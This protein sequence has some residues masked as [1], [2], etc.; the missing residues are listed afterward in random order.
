MKSIR[1][2]IMQIKGNR[3][4][5]CGIQ[6]NSRDPRHPTYATLEHIIP[7]AKGGMT[8]DD[9]LVIACLGCN[10]KKGNKT[11]AEFRA[12]PDEGKL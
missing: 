11:E 1:K 8:I 12:Q 2:Q 3:C 7:K 4:Y 6:T 9:N 5:Y 10:R